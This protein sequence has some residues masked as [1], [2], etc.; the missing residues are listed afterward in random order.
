[1]GKHVHAQAVD[2][3]ARHIGDV[4]AAQIR[5]NTP[6]RHNHDQGDGQKITYVFR[7]IQAQRLLPV[8]EARGRLVQARRGNPIERRGQILHQTGE[9]RLGQRVQNEADHADQKR[10]RHRTQIAKESAIGLQAAL[11]RGGG[12]VGGAVGCVGKRVVQGVLAAGAVPVLY[13]S[14]AYWRTR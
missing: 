9:R 1:M 11:H 12:V 7:F 13:G 6:Q 14:V 4:V 5:A 8:L 3:V 10:R 2:H